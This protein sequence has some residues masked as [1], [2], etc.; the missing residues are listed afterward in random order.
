MV[1]GAAVA[2]A[3]SRWRWAM[4]AGIWLLYFSFGLTM[5]GM[6]PLVSVM[7]ADLGVSLTAMGAIL[8]AW[9]LVYIVSA[10]PCGAFIDRAGL[11]AALALAAL[12]IAASGALR[13]AAV[14]PLSLFL[15]VALFGVGGPLVSVGAP[16]CIAQWFGE[17]ERGLAMGIYITGPALGGVLAL[18]LTNAVFMPRV[19]HSWRAVLL[20][21]AGVALAAAVAWLLLTAHPQSRAME[22]AA[23]AALREPQRAVFARLLRIPAVRL[24]LV[25][26]TG[27]FFFNHG[28]NNWLP[29][30][31][32]RG[33]MSAATA[34]I[35]AAVPTLVGIAGSLLI[36]RLAVPARR[37]AI[38]LALFAAAAAASLLLHAGPG[39]PLAAGLVLQGIARS[40]M[41]T[42][43]VLTLIETPGV[44]PRHRGAAG[45]LFFSAAEVGGVLGPLTIGAVADATDGFGTAL[46][47]VTGVCVLLAL[48]ARRLGRLR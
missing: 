10:M 9:P 39:V 12:V 16:K 14:G 23:A 22:R 42:I 18:S 13:A 31:L 45:G 38:L 7:V 4:L 3:P 40:S 32:R 17:R 44:E 29:E 28:L 26:S 43:A 25:M 46:W 33:G 15:A 6:A 19:D 20:L 34:G 27:I 36:P 47:M 2:P 35:W 11:R 21:Y 24:L 8:G 48:L 30:I 5:T 41:M 37:V 1:S